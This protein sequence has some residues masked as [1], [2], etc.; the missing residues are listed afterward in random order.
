M[1]VLRIKAY[2]SKKAVQNGINYVSNPEKTDISVS[3][4]AIKGSYEGRNAVLME[5][6]DTNAL[7]AFSYS[8]NADKT[9]LKDDYDKVLLVSGVNCMPESA[10]NQFLN[11]M[12][13]YYG[14]GHKEDLCPRKAKRI[15]KACLDQNGKPL[16]DEDGN[17]I[18]DENGTVIRDK[19]GK[20]IYQEYVKI[21]E[22]RTAYM[23]VLSYPPA[24]DL[25]FELDP[26]LVHKIGIEFCKKA[27]PE[28]K[29]TVST[30]MNTDCIHNH[31]MQCAFSEDG[32]HKYNDCMSSLLK[33]REIADE[34]S[35]KYGIP[36]IIEPQ[37]EKGISWFEWKSRKMGK[38]WKEQI[39]QDIRDTMSIAGSFDEFKEIM[40][41]SGYT[42]RETEN[43]ITYYM[44]GNDG[45]RCRDT[46]LNKGM[47]HGEDYTKRAI[48]KAFKDRQENRRRDEAGKADIQ[49][50]V[51][52]PRVHNAGDPSSLTGLSRSPVIYVSRYTD[53]GR[54]R[55]DLEIIL[56][57]AIKILKKAADRFA[58]KD[59][60]RIPQKDNPIYKPAS[61]KLQQ[62]QDS[63]C[64]VQEMGLNDMNGLEKRINE[65]GARLSHA[66]K[67]KADLESASH[68]AEDLLSRI[69]DLNDTLR[70]IKDLGLSVE[71]LYL[72]EYRDEEIRHHKASLTPMRDSQRRT[73]YLELEKSSDCRLKYKFA[74]ITMDE[75]QSA[76][77]YLKGRTDRKPSV[78]VDITADSEERKRIKYESIYKNRMYTMSNK[79]GSRKITKAQEK[80]LEEIFSG[81]D[82]YVDPDKLEK[83]QCRE[84]NT[85]NLS[86]YDAFRLINFFSAKL[87]LSS[88]I[89]SEERRDY[90]I[91][92]AKKNGDTVF[93][94]SEY[95]TEEDVTAVMKYYVSGRKCKT[96]AILKEPDPARE[97]EIIQCEELLSLKHAEI[98]VP[99]NA[100][101][102]DEVRDLFTALLLRDHVPEIL[103]NGNDKD[104]IKKD[105]LFEETVAGIPYEKQ[106]ALMD[107]RDML[108]SLLLNGVSI[109]NATEKETDLREIISSYE[110]MKKEYDEYRM[111]YRN[112]VRL[113][114]NLSLASKKEYTYGPLYIDEP[115][116]VVEEEYPCLDNGKE[117]LLTNLDS[118][119][120]KKS[121]YYK[122][123]DEYYERIFGI[124]V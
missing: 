14:N 12:R 74:D 109:D 26:R 94:K 20:C 95:I 57:A 39:R 76:I 106:Q 23:W 62:M 122:D 13:H 37:T 11:D 90:V 38:S 61:W 100:L 25:G 45:F 63:L 32:S 99:V 79:Y 5:G 54:R 64:M 56:I 58:Q 36:I 17:I 86:Y 44:P 34:L 30:H 33:A 83:Y 65:T 113:K 2:H 52:E 66:K 81:E 78:L 115:N 40:R 102:R 3:A 8:S 6:M 1:S 16:R 49:T 48:L 59:Q 104:R 111:E 15:L 28:Y 116:E 50:F 46:L 4:T 42:L 35:R 7:R 84:I 119:I 9:L 114:Y 105:L 19:D 108:C 121:N 92:L 47:A 27:L 60:S 67:Q 96:P 80:R 73:L 70:F 77:D 123:K 55:T 87:P 117:P 85:K 43:H 110:E 41:Q 31:I 103:D 53:L 107:A 89:A 18:Y 68:M 72:Y 124:D 22:P 51:F 88:P 118:G 120:E 97:S 69:D 82:K 71:D 29:C 101:S 91:E 75:A 10:V 93:R 21:P 98:C 112:L 24:S